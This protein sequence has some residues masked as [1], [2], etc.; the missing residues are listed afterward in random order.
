MLTTGKGLGS[1]AN[2]SCQAEAA[3]LSASESAWWRAPTVRSW[4]SKSTNKWPKSHMVTTWKRVIKLLTTSIVKWEGI[5]SSISQP[6]YPPHSY[7][8]VHVELSTSAKTKE[9][10]P[11]HEVST[12]NNH[13]E[14]LWPNQT[15]PDVI[16][17]VES[18]PCLSKRKELASNVLEFACS[19]IS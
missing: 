13:D 8:E 11:V 3:F 2:S 6:K 1:D 15:Y 12:G 10:A 14:E 17:D 16:L 5:C 7:Q 4:N 18:E 9:F 19:I